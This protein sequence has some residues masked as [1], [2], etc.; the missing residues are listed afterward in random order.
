MVELGSLKKPSTFAKKTIGLNMERIDIRQVQNKMTYAE[1][2]AKMNALLAEGKT[3]TTDDGKG[4]DLRHYTEMNMQRMRRLDKTTELA[5]ETVSVLS[6]IS[7]PLTWLTLTEGWCGDAAQIIPVIEKMA[8]IN[9]LISH[10]LIFRDEHLDIMDAFLTDG[11]RSIP[12]IIALNTV[13]E[14]SHEEGVVLG[15]WGPRP[16]TLQAIIQN[17]KIKMMQMDKEAR[18]AYFEEVKTDVQRWYNADKTQSIQRELIVEIK[19][20]MGRVSV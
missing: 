4:L 18:K 20:W 12:K 16:M 10:H 15:A 3:A 9:P 19:K 8:S 11:G 6:Q 2:I 14:D 1:Y 5:D 17:Q 7:K 13:R